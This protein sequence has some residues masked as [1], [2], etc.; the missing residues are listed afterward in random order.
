MTGGEDESRQ[1]SGA[2]FT[3]WRAVLGL[4]LAVEATRYLAHGWVEAHLVAPPF[5]FHYPGLEW[6]APLPGAWMR[7]W[8][9]VLAV[10]GLG[11]VWG[12]FTRHLAAL[13]LLG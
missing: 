7:M 5:H 3:L 9:I 8:M 4:A 11:I 10:L 1:V 2:S 12:R 13:S 6:V